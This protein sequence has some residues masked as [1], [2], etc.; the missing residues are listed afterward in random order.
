MRAID[1]N[2]VVRF[3]TGD[4]PPQA[5]RARGLIETCP[6]FVSTT[7]LLE[8]DWVLRYTYELPPKLASARLRA[9]AGLPGV[10]LEDWPLAVQAFDWTE[11]GMDF[12][13][14]LHL[15]RASGCDDFVSFDRALA[16]RATRLSSIAV[17]EP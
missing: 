15:G 2:V 5:M 16:R 1:T 9:F 3:I 14:A 4:D 12:A 8:S 10:T 17:A 11:Q 6:V 13:D 7:V